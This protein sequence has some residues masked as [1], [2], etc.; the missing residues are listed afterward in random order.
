[1]NGLIVTF[2][3][4]NLHEHGYLYVAL[5]LVQSVKKNVT[6][7]YDHKGLTS[8]NESKLNPLDLSFNKHT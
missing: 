3:N 7:N 8:I 1:M 5:S 4:L 6:F 2:Q